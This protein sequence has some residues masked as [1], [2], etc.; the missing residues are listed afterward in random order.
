MRQRDA[1]ELVLLAAIWGSSFLFMRIGVGDFGPAALAFVRVAGASLV[2]LPLLL[3][4]G[5][6]AAL[7]RHWRPILLVGITNSAVPFVCFSI[8]ALA[9]TGGLSAIFNA[10]APM[11][12]ALIAW[13]WLGDR[14]GRARALGLAMGFAGVLWLAWDKASLKA[15]EH[16]V[17][18]AL[19]IAACLLATLLYGFSANFTK[20]ALTGVPPLA[21]AA[22]SQ[23]AAALFL[24]LPAL[25]FAPPRM[26]GAAAWFAVTMLA[27]LCTGAAYVM[28]F[29]LLAHIGPANA[30]TVTFLVP[31][32]G[33]L[34]GALVLHEPLSFPMVGACLVILAGTALGTG[35]LRWP[36]RR[37]AG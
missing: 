23:V 35:Y 15:G 22:G 34:W 7:V 29:R 21:L 13:V 24:L 14:L 33:V 1:A 37:P 12:A 30:I 36:A 19:A 6:G 3:A 20:R 11:F 25:W 9:I 2:L 32:F 31:A 27:L 17:S 5:E 28:Y 8:A 26:P 10:T 4:R 18:P 16:G